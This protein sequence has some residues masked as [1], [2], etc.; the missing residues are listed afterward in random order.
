MKEYL[1]TYIWMDSPNPL[2]RK[3]YIDVHYNKDDGLFESV[4]LEV[5]STPRKVHQRIVHYNTH[6]YFIHEMY[7]GMKRIDNIVE[8]KMTDDR[9]IY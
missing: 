2:P 1:G 7:P 9:A 4:A 3:V 5:D 8:R 6:S